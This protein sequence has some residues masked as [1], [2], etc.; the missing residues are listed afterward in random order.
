VQ[1]ASGGVAVSASAKTG[2]HGLEVK[3]GGMAKYM[4]T[5]VPGMEVPDDLVKRVASAPKE[6]QAEEGIKILLEQIEQEI[7]RASCRERV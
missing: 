4:A 3:S 2:G 5:K 1:G 7:G 6:A